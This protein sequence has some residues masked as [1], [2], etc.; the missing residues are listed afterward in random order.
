MRTSL[1]CVKQLTRA[2]QRNGYTYFS[3]C[4]EDL[5]IS[6]RFVITRIKNHVLIR[7]A[8]FL[9]KFSIPITLPSEHESSDEEWEDA[10]SDDD[11]DEDDGSEGMDDCEQSTECLIEHH[12][13]G[14]EK[15][16]IAETGDASLDKL[17]AVLR[18][19]GGDGIFTPLDGTALFSML[20]KIN[21]SCDPNVRVKYVFTREHGM[22]ARLV[23]LR[24][25][26]P[27]EELLQSYIDQSMGKEWNI[28]V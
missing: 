17:K 3:R 6:R 24:D 22:V 27:D 16:D 8:D 4:R 21:H 11:C 18:E 19:Y 12:H 25:I 26:D 13:H 1:G 20:C 5:A 9:T 15:M 28:A 23:A 2:A 7:K 10:D 14:Q